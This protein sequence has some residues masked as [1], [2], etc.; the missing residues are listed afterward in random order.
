M[1]HHAPHIYAVW[2]SQHPYEADAIISPNVRKPT[3]KEVKELA[4]DFQ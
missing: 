3:F 4:K 2:S 1:L